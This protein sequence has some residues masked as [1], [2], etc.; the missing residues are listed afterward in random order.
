MAKVETLEDRFKRIAQQSHDY[1]EFKNRVIAA[2]PEHLRR[3][4]QGRLLAFYAEYR[5]DTE[6]VD[7]SDEGPHTA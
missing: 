5:A 6:L 3:S 4:I 7:S 1:E 2:T